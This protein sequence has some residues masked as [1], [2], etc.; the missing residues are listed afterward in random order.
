MTIQDQI[1]RHLAIRPFRIFWLETTS[2][3]QVR[4]ARPEWFYSIPDSQGDFWIFADGVSHVL[5]YRDVLEPLRLK[6]QRAPSLTTPGCRR[7]DSRSACAHP[8][9]Q[10]CRRRFS[11]RLA[12]KARPL[13]GRGGF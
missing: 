9:S 6:A 2:G 7:P 12:R 11:G 5:N 3:N 1:A 10:R 4:V 13:L 8:R